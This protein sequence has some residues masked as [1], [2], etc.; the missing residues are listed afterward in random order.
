MQLEATERRRM[1]NA[2]RGL[3][4]PEKVRRQ[5]QR[6]TKLE[7]NEL[8]AGKYG[9]NATLRVTLLTLSRLINCFLIFH[10]QWQAY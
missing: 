4:D 8:E 1:E 9:N 5:Q 10:F 6:A 2:N 3:K 7:Q